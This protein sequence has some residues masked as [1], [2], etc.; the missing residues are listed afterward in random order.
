MKIIGNT[1]VLESG[2]KLNV[3]VVSSAAQSSNQHT[4]EAA[5]ASSEAQ[6]GPAAAN[7]LPGKPIDMTLKIVNTH[8]YAI[9]IDNKINFV[10]AN[11]CPNGYYYGD[12]GGK[13]W[14]GAYNRVAVI[15]GKEY[16]A[17]S[18][19]IPANSEVEFQVRYEAITG[20][21]YLNDAKTVFATNLLTGLGGR[22]LAEDSVV[23][24]PD[25]PASRGKSNVLLYVDGDSNVIVPECLSPNIK[26]EQNG[27]YVLKV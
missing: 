12:N 17:K 13:A 9:T 24:G 1:I 22:N 2:D 6:Q 15:L 7:G 25:W 23:K 3:E 5:P 18:I 8:P 11:P 19:T 16:K 21:V 20:V 14:T 10:L 26:F 4:S 27:V